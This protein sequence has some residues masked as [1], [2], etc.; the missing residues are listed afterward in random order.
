M[1]IFFGNE[2][3][4]QDKF[5]PNIT[6][7]IFIFLNMGLGTVSAFQLYCPQNCVVNQPCT[8]AA[9]GCSQGMTIIKNLEGRPIDVSGLIAGG[10][11]PVNMFSDSTYTRSFKAV[12]GGTVLFSAI[13]FDSQNFGIQKRQIEVFPEG[14]A[15]Q[16]NSCII[17][18]SA[19]GTTCAPGS[20][21]G[22]S[23][24]NP[25]GVGWTDNSS[26]CNS[27]Q[28]CRNGVCTDIC[29]GECLTN[30]A[31]ECSGTAGY[32]T[33]SDTN[34]DGCL[35]WSGSTDCAGG[36]RCVDGQC[37]E[38]INCPHN[39]WYT[40]SSGKTCSSSGQICDEVREEYRIY[41][42]N[43]SYSTG[44]ARVTV[45]NCQ[46]CGDDACQGNIYMQ[47][48]CISGQCVQTPKTCSD[49]SCPCGDYG[50]QNETGFCNDSKDNDCDGKADYMD[51]D[52]P[53]S[54]GS[55][56]YANNS[57]R[58]GQEIYLNCSV[59]QGSSVCIEAK[60]DGESCERLVGGQFRCYLDGNGTKAIRC[61]V[62]NSCCVSG[63]REISRTIWVLPSQQHKS[64][65]QYSYDS[66]CHSDP[67]CDWC[68]ECSGRKYG[69][70]GSA[71]REKGKCTY[72]CTSGKC[73]SGCEGSKD[74]KS[75][76]SG[77][78]YYSPVGCDGNCTCI[79]NQTSCSG[80]CG[81]CK[82]YS[83]MADACACKDIQNCCGNGICESGETCN[84]CA[85]DCRCNSES[86]SPSASGDDG[87][88]SSDRERAQAAI[89]ELEQQISSS[90]NAGQASSL[91]SQAKAELASEKCSKALELANEGKSAFLKE[92]SQDF[93]LYIIAGVGITALIVMVLAIYIWGRR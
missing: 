11:F 55:L 63:S 85:L 7:I 8:C 52:C 75:Y 82:E 12:S 10:D 34:N 68:Y 64:C 62:K 18:S 87:G 33:C 89:D 28:G 6:I 60:I 57:P 17:Q 43:C 23:V 66:A 31:V 9:T 51:C 88:C 92:N 1:G 24:C 80:S 67:N 81:V 69:I 47:Y 54:L 3:K 49:C 53:T 2:Q 70:Y 27:T 25:D 20:I 21:S 74:C 78:I 48:L 84:T 76:C 5:S 56:D 77:G 41:L 71:C 50:L 86:N 36:E 15:C 46:S 59:S 37:V 30:G 44:Q 13:C 79:Y 4:A 61:L 83:C 73:G 39:G 19:N 72:A 58:E 65:S 90:G 42:A 32:R 40:A 26:L 14:V 38:N 93:M 35:E 45:S 91:L 22:C 16:N 29:T